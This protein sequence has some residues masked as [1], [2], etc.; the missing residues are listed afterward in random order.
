MRVEDRNQYFVTGCVVTYWQL[1]TKGYRLVRVSLDSL[2]AVKSLNQNETEL[3][4]QSLQY[5]V[6]EVL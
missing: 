4:K 5:N 2:L 6:T 1:K 3:R